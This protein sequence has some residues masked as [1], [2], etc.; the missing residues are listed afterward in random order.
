[1]DMHTNIES[2]Q[3]LASGSILVTIDGQKM[4]IPNDPGNR[5]YAAV[6][7]WGTPTPWVAPIPMLEE[8]QARITAAINAHVEARAVELKYNDAASIASYVSSTVARYAADATAFIAWRDSVWL[9]AEEMLAEAQQTGVI[10]TVEEA[11]A[12]LPKWLGVK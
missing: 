10:P 2:A 4:T 12:K 11:I 3:Y 7:A 5:H 9:T 8:L 1:M 6:M